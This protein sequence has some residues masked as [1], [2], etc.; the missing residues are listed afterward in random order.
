MLPSLRRKPVGIQASTQT[1]TSIDDQPWATAHLYKNNYATPASE[2]ADM[3]N[4]ASDKI[5]VSTE[6]EQ[7]SETE[8]VDAITPLPLSQVHID[9]IAGHSNVTVPARRP[10]QHTLSELFDVDQMEPGSQVRS[11]S[12]NMLSAEQ[13]AVREDRPM[14]IKER[15]ENIRRKVAEQRQQGLGNEV[16]VTG[17]AKGKEKRERE[18]REREGNGKREKIKAKAK[19]LAGCRCQ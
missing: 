17:D 1:T 4:R 16:T 2:N 9:P 7:H 12:G 13:L 5:P 8:D 6:N 3:P 15:Q 18:Q 11:P 14:G 19:A 10:R